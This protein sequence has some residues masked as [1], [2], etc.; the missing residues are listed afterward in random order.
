VR[1][2]LLAAVPAAALLVFTGCSDESDEDS[3]VTV[4]LSEWSV[5]ADPESVQ[6]G[7]VTFDAEN[8][9]EEDHELLVVR[10]DFGAEELP[11]EDNG[12][13]DEGADGID[14]V[15]ET[16]EIE[17]GDS[18]S[19]VF[20]LD[21]GNYVLLCNRVSDVDGEDQSHYELGMRTA[22]EVTEGE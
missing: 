22:F 15:G 11:T 18:D 14:V 12:S 16:N 5:A 20:G 2:Y 4:T 1:A 7:D 19:R 9:G 6:E 8:D 10:T 13:V 21:A 3:T 17:S